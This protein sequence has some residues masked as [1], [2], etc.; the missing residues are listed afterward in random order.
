MIKNPKILVGTLYSGEAQFPD[1]VTA[2]ESQN[3]Q[4]WEHKVF[5][6]LP[7]KQAH[8]AIYKYFMRSS[9]NFDLSLKLDADMVFLRKTCLEE[10][11]ALFKKNTDLVHLQSAVH[12]WLTN[13]QIMG[14]HA[15][16]SDAQ[17][18]ISGETLF[19]DLQP[20]ISGK[21]LDLWDH[22]APFVIHNPNPSK[23]Q[24]FHF[25]VHRALKAIQPSHLVFR[26]NQYHAQTD[27][28]KKIWNN[29]LSFDDIRQGHA[30][31]GAYL[32]FQGKIQRQLYDYTNPDLKRRYQK[33]YES[34]DRTELMDLMKNFWSLDSNMYKPVRTKFILNRIVKKCL[35]MAKRTS[36]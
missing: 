33:N 24:A 30:A 35:S 21:R 3:Y 19:V 31:L 17:W 28:L 9:D 29:F 15:F 2:L 36:S 12:D 22:P 1:C 34:L 18:N 32:V 14:L 11:I 5:R 7:N 25:G 8:D 27:M 4:N 16:R 26:E 10:I 13:S 23:F 6:F 20:E